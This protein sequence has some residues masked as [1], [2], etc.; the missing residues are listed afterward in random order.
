MSRGSH[1]RGLPIGGEPNDE[2]DRHVLL[3]AA[4]AAADGLRVRLQRGSD[5]E[6]VDTRTP[7]RARADALGVCP[8]ARG[9][10]RSACDPRQTCSTTP[11]TIPTRDRRRRPPT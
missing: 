3:V 11:R 7:P 5:F 8:L 2:G 6:L 1:Y 9:G 4:T 10:S